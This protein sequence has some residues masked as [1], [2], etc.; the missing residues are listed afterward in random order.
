LESN[1]HN[2]F[3]LLLQKEGGLI[4]EHRRWATHFLDAEDDP[5]VLWLNSEHRVLYLSMMA[6]DFYEDLDMLLECASGLRCL[7]TCDDW[8]GVE[9]FMYW[10]DNYLHADRPTNL[11]T[12]L[13]TDPSPVKEGLVK[14]HEL[15]T[16]A[17][18]FRG[19]L[20]IYVKLRAQ[21]YAEFVS[22]R[23]SELLDTCCCRLVLFMDKDEGPGPSSFFEGRQSHVQQRQ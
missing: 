19:F 10:V 21:C 3:N 22:L 7:H 6:C 15:A 16:L 23:L 20:H 9:F 12:G 1:Y 2:Q 4:R 18:I 5:F 13:H 11:P 8:Q 14:A 17:G